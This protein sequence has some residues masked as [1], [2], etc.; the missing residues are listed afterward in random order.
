MLSIIAVIAGL[1]VEA[2]QQRR[3]LEA[4]WLRAAESARG[5]TLLAATCAGIYGL[6]A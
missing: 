6:R 3:D 1:Y 2:N 5:K 4:L